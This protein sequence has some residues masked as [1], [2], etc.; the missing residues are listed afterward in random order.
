M[1]S[2]FTSFVQH[3]HK[4]GC[5]KKF[6]MSRTFTTSQAYLI[7]YQLTWS[8]L[9][10]DLCCR[11]NYAFRVS[12][13]VKWVP[14]LWT[15]THIELDLHHDD[16]ISPDWKIPNTRPSDLKP[17]IRYNKLYTDIDAS[18]NAN[19]TGGN[20]LKF[21]IRSSPFSGCYMTWILLFNQCWLKW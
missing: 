18:E 10:G 9:S 13:E 3:Y 7:L 16:I 8:K 1:D 6:K 20:L 21:M 12:T 2:I 19:N 11:I 15:C 17:A 14:R 5:N 4:N